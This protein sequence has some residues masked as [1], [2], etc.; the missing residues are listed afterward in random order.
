MGDVVR[1]DSR[2]R[3]HRLFDGSLLRSLIPPI[4]GKDI[5]H[6]KERNTHHDDKRQISSTHSAI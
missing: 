6:K 4:N 2:H 3:R 5:L 1:I